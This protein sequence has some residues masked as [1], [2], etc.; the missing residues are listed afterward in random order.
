M[1]IMLLLFL[2]SMR[3]HSQCPCIKTAIIGVEEKEQI[4]STYNNKVVVMDDVVIKKGESILLYTKKHSG[5]LLW[6]SKGKRIEN[7]RVT[8][9]ETTA[10]TVKSFLEGCP[11]AYDMVTITVNQNPDVQELFVFPNPVHAKTTLVSTSVPIKGVSI[12]DLKGNQIHS[13]FYTDYFRQR[14]IDLSALTKGVYL[15]RVLL[16]NQNSIST[17]IIKT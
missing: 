13:F 15:I 11:D 9:N 3:T 10:Y 4:T 2:M 5:E 16:D 12:Y 6:Y 1:K 14:V 8:P 17:K 7:T